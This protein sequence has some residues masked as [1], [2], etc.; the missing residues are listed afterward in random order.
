[1]PSIHKITESIASVNGL[2][3]ECVGKWGVYWRGAF[4]FVVSTKAEARR[5]REELHRY[6]LNT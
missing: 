1:M 6:W 2:P 3:L 4:A 5:K